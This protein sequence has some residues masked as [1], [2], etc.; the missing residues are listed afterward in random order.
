M[1]FAEPQRQ[2]PEDNK[3]CVKDKVLAPAKVF[4]EQVAMAWKL[5]GPDHH[6]TYVQSEGRHKA[7]ESVKAEILG[8][9]D[10]EQDCNKY[11]HHGN[12]PAYSHGERAN[13]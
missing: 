5:I 10:G 6:S 9:R 1:V 2:Y 8:F 11:F 4:N 7:C 3:A 13:E 12:Q